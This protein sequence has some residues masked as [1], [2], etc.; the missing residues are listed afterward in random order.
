MEVTPRVTW[1]D[2]AKAREVERF[3]VGDT[4]VPPVLEPS[5]RRDALVTVTLRAQD[6]AGGS[7]PPC[8]DV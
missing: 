3:I 6:D 5:A 4:G 2:D 7:R 8:S 1:R